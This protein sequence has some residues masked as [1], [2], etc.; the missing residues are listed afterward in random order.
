M[1]RR[2]RNPPPRRKTAD[3]DDAVAAEVMNVVAADAVADVDEDLL[4][5][6]L[7]SDLRR[8]EEKLRPDCRR[9]RKSREDS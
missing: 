5:P 2:K 3:V 4:F 9:C 8:F 1:A 6:P 7:L